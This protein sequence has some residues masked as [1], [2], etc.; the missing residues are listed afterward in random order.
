ML[1]K[2]VKIFFPLLAYYQS[3]RSATYPSR[4]IRT[5]SGLADLEKSKNKI[6]TSFARMSTVSTRRGPASLSLRDGACA[7][8]P[9]KGLRDSYVPEIRSPLEDLTYGFRRKTTG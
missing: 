7:E 9:T 4:A 2:G 5:S 1:H 6:G 3:R 8:E